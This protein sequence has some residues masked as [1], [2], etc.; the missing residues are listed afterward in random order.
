MGGDIRPKYRCVWEF[1]DTGEIKINSLDCA[2]SLKDNVYIHVCHTKRDVE[3]DATIDELHKAV[4]DYIKKNDK[5][6]QINYE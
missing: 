1:G 4:E 5:I 2:A 6:K 3:A